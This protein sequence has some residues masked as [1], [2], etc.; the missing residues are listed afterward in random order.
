MISADLRRILRGPMHLRVYVG[1]F[2]EEW[3]MPAGA[4]LTFDECNC[5]AVSLVSQARHAILRSVISTDGST[6]TQSTILAK[7]QNLGTPTTN[8]LAKAVVIDRTTLGR[9]ILPLERRP[10]AS[11]GGY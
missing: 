11:S 2:Y 8:M 1:V 10:T 7:L 9:Y 3:S 5:L 6:D 4:A